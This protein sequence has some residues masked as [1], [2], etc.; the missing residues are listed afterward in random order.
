M[1]QANVSEQKSVATVLGLHHSGIPCNDLDR[2][3]EFYQRVLGME[4]NGIMGSLYGHFVESGKA[5]A[6]LQADTT[7]GKRDLEEFKAIYNKARPNG[8][9]ATDQAS[10]L[11]A[12]MRAGTDD[13]VLF[14][15]PEPIEGDTLIENGILHQSF[16]IS[17][18]DMERLVRLKQEGNSGIR[19]HT[20]PVPRWPTG[21][22]IYLWDTEGNYLEL[23]CEDRE[24]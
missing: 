9:P 16:S 14:K 5:P 18:E 11:F 10:P 4:L 7:D 17:V 20:G 22:A 13:V 23:E 3:V 12:R 21:R 15:R 19:F 2:A 8:A 1:A 6:G 24:R